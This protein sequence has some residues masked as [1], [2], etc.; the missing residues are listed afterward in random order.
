AVLGVT[1]QPSKVISGSVGPRFQGCARFLSRRRAFAR[2]AGAGAGAAV[3]TKRDDTEVVGH[4]RHENRGCARLRQL[5]RGRNMCP[6]GEFLPLPRKSGLTREP[7]ETPVRIP[8]LAP[9]LTVM[10]AP[11]LR[12]IFSKKRNRG[13]K[14]VSVQRAPRPLALQSLGD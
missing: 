11:R 12:I 5:P 8:H 1:D 14:K 9:H 6:A 13:A 4:Q 10:S 3:L 7:F 2:T